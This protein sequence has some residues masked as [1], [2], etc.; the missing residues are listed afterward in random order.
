[1][2]RAAAYGVLREM[3]SELHN[4]VSGSSSGGAGSL[5]KASGPKIKQV[6]DYANKHPEEY[7]KLASVQRNA[8]EVKGIVIENVDR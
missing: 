3:K 1:M 8:D 4:S 7:D 6:L 2:K 5:Q